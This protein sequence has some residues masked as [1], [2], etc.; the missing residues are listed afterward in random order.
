M[1]HSVDRKSAISLERG[2][3]D[4]KFQVEGVAPTNYSFS[5]RTRLNDLSYGIKIWNDFS[6]VLSQFTRLMDRQTD[7]RTYGQNSHR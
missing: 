3:F 1:G 4:A 6:S 7:G 2:H 5:Q